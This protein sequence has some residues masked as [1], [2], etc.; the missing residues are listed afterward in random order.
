MITIIVLL[1][2]LLIIFNLLPSYNL[3]LIYLVSPLIF[4]LKQNNIP[5]QRKWLLFIVQIEDI[6]NFSNNK[7]RI[8]HKKR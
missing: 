5:S 3:E 8:E 4:S 6:M 2:W 1:F 7:S